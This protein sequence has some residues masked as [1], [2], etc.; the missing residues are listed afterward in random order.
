MVGELDGCGVD[1]PVGLG[2]ANNRAR[3]FMRM[4]FGLEQN[5]LIENVLQKKR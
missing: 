1:I 5:Q 4:R 2:F 3:T